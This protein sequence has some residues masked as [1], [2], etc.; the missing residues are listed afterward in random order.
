MR[1]DNFDKIS[2]LLEFGEDTYYFVQIIKRRKDPGNEELKTPEVCLWQ[3]FI[4]KPETLEHL[5]Q[6]V[7]R[8]CDLFNARAYIELN[9]RSLEKWSM[10]LAKRLLERISVHG[11]QSIHRLPFKVA[12]SEEIVK[13]RGLP[14]IKQRRWLLDVDDISNISTV[15]SWIKETGIKEVATIP[16]LNGVHK[17]IES[18]NYKKH[19][20]KLGGYVKTG[21]TEFILSPNAN[22]LLYY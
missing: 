6:E 8:I 12:L 2:P 7:C 19:S 17:I 16:T 20:L 10:E 5:K 11:F 1:I 15:E 18:F 3:R 13:T 4:D 21:N 22:T 9:P 14:T